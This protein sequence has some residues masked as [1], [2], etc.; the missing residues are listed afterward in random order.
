VHYFAENYNPA[1]FMLE[2]ILCCILTLLS[3]AK[4][5]LESPVPWESKPSKF[6]LVYLGPPPYFDGF[7]HRSQG[8]KASARAAAVL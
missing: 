2:Q 5:W 4:G 3:C 1:D 8:S 7:P 6:Q